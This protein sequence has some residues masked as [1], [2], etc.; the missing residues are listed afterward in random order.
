M[1]HT[2]LLCSTRTHGIPDVIRHRA[3]PPP[4]V[5]API[6][7]AFLTGIDFADL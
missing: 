1:S 5:P 3:I 4:I 6:T 7:P 2:S